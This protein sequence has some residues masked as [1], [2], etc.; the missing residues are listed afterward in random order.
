MTLGTSKSNQ[1]EAKAARKTAIDD[2]LATVTVFNMTPEQIMK[3]AS[4]PEGDRIGEAVAE[5]ILRHLAEPRQP[6]TDGRVARAKRRILD[7]DTLPGDTART[8]K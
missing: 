2:T 1:P 7:S 4:D 8:G 5:A 3:G 6:T